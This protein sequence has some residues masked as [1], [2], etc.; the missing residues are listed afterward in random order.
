M[1]R[2][3]KKVQREAKEAVAAAAEEEARKI[4]E[5]WCPPL[6]K[7]EQL[8]HRSAQLGDEFELIRHL[9]RP[10]WED[11]INKRDEYGRTP[12]ICAAEGGSALEK[13]RALRPVDE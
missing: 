7:D 9:S 2:N 11:R 13:A 6:S 3:I 5:D 8:M 10:G 12:L 1:H 4:A